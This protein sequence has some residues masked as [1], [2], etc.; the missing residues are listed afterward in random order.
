MKINIIIIDSDELYLRRLESAFDEFYPGKV[1]IHN[2]TSMEIAENNLVKKSADVLLVDESIVG[3]HGFPETQ[4]NTKA[5]AVLTGAQSIEKIGGVETVC[6]YQ[7]ID[8]IYKEIVSVLSEN[9][10]IKFENSGADNITKLLTFTSA[11]GGVGTSTVAAACAIRLAS[12]NAKVLYLDTNLYAS[13]DTFFKDEGNFTLSDVVY[14]IIGKK[15]NAS[16]KVNVFAKKDPCGVFYYSQC[17]NVP[18]WLEMSDEDKITLI[19]YLQESGGYDYIIVDTYT[20]FSEYTRHLFEI[21]QQIFCVSDGSF[22]VNKKSER[23]FSTMKI[24]DTQTEGDCAAKL[25]MLYNKYSAQAKQVSNTEME[26]FGTVY[27]AT[28]RTKISDIARTVSGM[29]IWNHIR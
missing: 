4:I 19:T 3:A 17:K 21:S 23:L 20:D 25:K 6:K 27:F 7:R 29:D 2:F 26:T 16:V 5:R 15:S 11:V 22:L 8:I 1:E 18:D 10:S 9:D 13:A 12:Q 14:T 24:Y 28:D